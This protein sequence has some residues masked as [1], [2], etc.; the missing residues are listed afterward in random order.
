MGGE[1]RL[2]LSEMWAFDFANSAWSKIAA[3]DSVQPARA[4]HGGRCLHLNTCDR[5][6]YITIW[7]CVVNIHSPGFIFKMIEQLSYSQCKCLMHLQPSF[8]LSIFVFYCPAAAWLPDGTVAIIGGWHQNWPVPSQGIILRK[9][10]LTPPEL[11]VDASEVTPAAEPAPAGAGRAFAS[12]PN[13]ELGKRLKAYVSG[14]SDA[15]GV[16]ANFS[17]FSDVVLVAQGGREFPA[18]RVILAA[19]SDVFDTMLRW[20]LQECG[21]LHY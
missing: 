8:S 18:H 4:S 6:I 7:C 21:G 19:Q 1:E 17:A 13:T 5:H 12:V 3:P 16:K 2:V 11:G 15:A 20:V 10:Y 14:A 9:R